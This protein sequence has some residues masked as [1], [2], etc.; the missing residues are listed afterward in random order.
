MK[1]E[2]INRKENNKYT[3]KSP[4]SA[5]FLYI[6]VFGT[7]LLTIATRKTLSK[8]GSL[9]MNN[10][11]SVKQIKPFIRKNKID[12]SDYPDR[13]YKS[14]NDFFTREI[15]PGRRPFSKD[16][17]ILISPADS[18]LLYYK[19]SDK[20]E[21]NIKGKK[22]NVKEL[23]RDKELA[24]EYRNGVCLVFR[25]SVD[26]Y[27]R[28]SYIDEGCLVRRKK[29][30]GILHTVGPVAFKRHKVFKQN[31]R[32]YSIL[33]TKN[34]GKIIQM[35]VGAMMVGKIKN[36]NKTEFVRGEEKGYF[37]FGGSTVVLLLKE[38]IVEIDKDIIKN[39][40]N[41]IE[42]R[43]LQGETVGRKIK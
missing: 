37:L 24:E 6:P 23:L 12:M 2:I 30:R 42:T 14:F 29:L 7:V 39:S 22:Y 34:F 4:K 9:Y 26:D 38:N 35:E 1:H 31:Q 41:D 11:A 10:K 28:Y 18:K 33:E 13:E 32:E 36:H 20:V 17:S 5:A 15:I 19:I 40:E 25:L 16:K 43:V 27:H 3:E 21:M 8:A